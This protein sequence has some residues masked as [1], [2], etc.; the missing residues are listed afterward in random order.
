L[1]L[2]ATRNAL[3]VPVVRRKWVPTFE[4]HWL[5][6]TGNRRDV[7]WLSG[8]VKTPTFCVLLVFSVEVMEKYSDACGDGEYYI[9]SGYSATADVS[10]LIASTAVDWK[11]MGH[12]VAERSWRDADF[13]CI[14]CLYPGG[15]EEVL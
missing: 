7:R 15:Y 4:W 14:S 5:P 9:R 12:T 11:S 8:R 2:A 3:S 1:T 6:L 13:L 10:V